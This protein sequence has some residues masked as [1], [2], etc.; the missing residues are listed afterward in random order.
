MLCSVLNVENC[1]VKSISYGNILVTVTFTRK[2]FLVI[3]AIKCIGKDI[4]IKLLACCLSC[5]YVINT[6]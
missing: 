4:E 6:C 2:I 1:S 3:S 5:K